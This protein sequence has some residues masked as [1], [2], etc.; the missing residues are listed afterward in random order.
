MA[1]AVAEGGGIQMLQ[2]LLLICHS[3]PLGISQAF[4]ERL[5]LRWRQCM[6]QLLARQFSGVVS[7]V[8]CVCCVLVTPDTPLGRGGGWLPASLRSLVVLA[9]GWS[10]RGGFTC[11]VCAVRSLLASLL[12]RPAGD[13]PCTPV[14]PDCGSAVGK[15]C[16]PL[17]WRLSTNPRLDPAKEGCWAKGLKCQRDVERTK[18]GNTP[19]TPGTCVAA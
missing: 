12:T 3:T 10:H 11:A 1:R 15:P 8:C 18:S 13:Y 5:P 16:C 2:T 7:Q 14:A 19:P 4:K 9:G 6:F 17:L